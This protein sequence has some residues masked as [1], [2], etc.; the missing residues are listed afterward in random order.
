MNHKM[1]FVILSF[2]TTTALLL[3]VQAGCRQSD[4]T[5]HIKILDSGIYSGLTN[6]D[7]EF[8]V[9]SDQEHLVEV[10]NRIYSQTY[11]V[12]DMYRVDFNTNVV[13][14]AFMGKKPTAG[15]SIS[16]KETAGIQNHRLRITVIIQTPPEN[17]FLPQVITNPYEL[18]VVDRAE[19]NKVE[20]VDEDGNILQVLD[21]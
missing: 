17:A 14:A 13:L 6:T 11:P 3:T 20:F 5:L 21:F 4:I 8:A 18:A 9:I 1:L 16:F 7:M 10:F 2:L 12:A 15:Y 19:Y